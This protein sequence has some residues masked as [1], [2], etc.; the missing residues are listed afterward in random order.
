MQAQT[1]ST[2]RGAESRQYRGTR[3][4]GRH[5]TARCAAP[6]WHDAGRHGHRNRLFWL[7]S[8]C[9]PPGDAGGNRQNLVWRYWL[10]ASALG[11]ASLVTAGVVAGRS[12][13]ETA[14][15]RHG[16]ILPWLA[17]YLGGVLLPAFYRRSGPTPNGVERD[18]RGRRSRQPR[19]G[20]PARRRAWSLSRDGA[21]TRC[22]APRPGSDSGVVADGLRTRLPRLSERA[23][24]RG[25][26]RAGRLSAGER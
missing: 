1:G 12:V 8:S 7:V 5:D 2:R 25:R 19:P 9:T 16:V 10:G 23:P 13:Q 6:E 26:R 24:V 21:G 3:R 4:L 22:A 20:R 18:L 17:I 15:M 11:I 14:P